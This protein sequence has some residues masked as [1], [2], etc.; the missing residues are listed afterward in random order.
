MVF[1][2]LKEDVFNLVLKMFLNEAIVLKALLVFFFLIYLQYLVFF[3]EVWWWKTG[4]EHTFECFLSVNI[5]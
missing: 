3:I 4:L 5:T 2:V 1:Y